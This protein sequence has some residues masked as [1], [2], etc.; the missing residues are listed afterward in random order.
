MPRGDFDRV[1]VVCKEPGQRRWRQ[2]PEAAVSPKPEFGPIFS[3]GRDALFET[4][5]VVNGAE[6]NPRALRLQIRQRREEGVVAAIEY[7]DVNPID[8]AARRRDESIGELYRLAEIGGLET[9]PAAERS[10]TEMIT[11][12]HAGWD[13]RR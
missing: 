5:H 6:I 13:V 11:E 9:R 12:R 1:Q 8:F 7:R 10:K 4:G 2:P 3:G